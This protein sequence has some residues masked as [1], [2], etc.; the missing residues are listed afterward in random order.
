M[1]QN[2][3]PALLSALL[4]SVVS[5]TGAA[6]FFLSS[7]RMKK[8]MPLL[9]A[10]AAGAMLGNSLLHLLPH[11]LESNS[12]NAVAEQA[13][14]HDDPEHADHDDDHG[15]HRHSRG[16][17]QVVGL[18][19]LGFFLLF[20]LD[21]I[22]LATT[23]SEGQHG[24]KPLGYLVLVTD[25][26]ENFIDGLL[27][28]AA[29]MISVPV[30]IATSIA[31]LIHEVPMELGDFAVLTHAGF[32]RTKALLLNLLSALVNVVGVILAFVLGA[33][34]TGFASL[35]AP[36][37][38]GAIL[39]LAATGLLSQLRHHGNARQKLACFAV[40]LFGVLLMALILLLE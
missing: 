26:L 38:A 1:F 2:M 33:G 36:V 25:G 5:F 28:G 12:A 24:A 22:L 19:L 23:G 7:D 8:V 29:F 30:G 6:T 21:L 9:L 11:A 34:I 15:H 35:A 10:L 14:D 16:T 31:V 18:L 32:G 20:G 37:A 4:I 3:L 17:L 40:T 39:Y 13:H 27:I